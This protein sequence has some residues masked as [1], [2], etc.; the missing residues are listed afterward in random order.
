M[1]AR[2]DIDIDPE[3]NCHKTA[4]GGAENSVDTHRIEVRHASQAVAQRVRDWFAGGK[5]IKILDGS[6]SVRVPHPEKRGFDLKIKGAG[7]RGSSV[8]F[9]MR[10][11][12][13]PRA[14]IFDFDGRMMED[15]A[16]GHANAFVGGA[17]FQQAATEFRISQILSGMGMAVVPC[18]GYGQVALAEHTSWFSVFEW[19]RSWSDAVVVPSISLQE[20][21]EANLRMGQL[22]V[23]LAVQHDL[24]GYCW[25]V[26]APDG[27]YLI[28]D[29]HPFRQADPVNM[30][31]LSWVM[32]VLF[33]LHIRCLA[34][35]HYPRVAK[36]E[37]PALGSKGSRRPK[38]K[39]PKNWAVQGRPGL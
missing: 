6:R 39:P 19:D 2:G 34:C 29:V 27:T 33:A 36:L 30:S 3:L 11:R 31:Q 26:S 9:G 37:N 5:R 10:H 16:S 14:P 23:D 24:I 32:Q 17:S 4:V 22:I 25:Y 13:G 28:K 7:F 38:N 21:I 15:V 20:Y 8:R 35:Q 1:P 12:Q 18:V